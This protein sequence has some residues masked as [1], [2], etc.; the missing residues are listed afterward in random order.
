MEQAKDYL[1]RYSA[2]KAAHL[3]HF[4]YA[5]TILRQE[6]EPLEAGKFPDLYWATYY[7]MRKRVSKNFK[8]SSHTPVTPKNIIKRFAASTL[9]DYGTLSEENR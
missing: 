2:I 1:S 5:R 8:T 3:Q 9:I 4:E 7:S 6:I